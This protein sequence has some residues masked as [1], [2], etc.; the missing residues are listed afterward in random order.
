MSGLVSEFI[1]IFKS[2]GLLKRSF[3]YTGI[4][5]CSFCLTVI[6]FS[7]QAIKSKPGT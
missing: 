6:V 3:L 5:N 7:E 2:Q 4:D 1:F